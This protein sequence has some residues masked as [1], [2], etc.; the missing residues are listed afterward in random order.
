MAQ[1][2]YSK[3]VIERPDGRTEV[4]CRR[5]AVDPNEAFRTF[6]RSGAGKVTA[7]RHEHLSEGQRTPRTL[8]IYKVG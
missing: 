3:I 8:A 7:V 6:A 4:V 5:G 1:G 2:P